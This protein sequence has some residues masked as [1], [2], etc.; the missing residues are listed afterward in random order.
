MKILITGGA[1]YIGSHVV[2]GLGEA[3]G[4]DI[5]V[6]DNLSTGFEDSVLYGKL[7]QVCQKKIKIVKKWVFLIC[8]YM[9]LL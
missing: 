2:K 4:F 1:G 7:T 9:K 6:L 3:G 5:T 8:N